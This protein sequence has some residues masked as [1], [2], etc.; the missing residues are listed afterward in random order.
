MRNMVED[1]LSNKTGPDALFTSMSA[2]KKPRSTIRVVRR[3]RYLHESAGNLPVLLEHSPD[4]VVLIDPHSIEVSWAIL[5]CNDVTC[6]INGYTRKELIGRSIDILNIHPADPEERAQ[7]MHR[8]RTEGT[9]HIE[10]WHKHKNG[11]LLPIEVSTSLVNLGGRELVLGIDRDIS[12]RKCSE[13]TLER[14]RRQLQLILVSAG[15]GILG[16]DMAGN[17]TF[18]NPAAARMVGWESEQL[19]G[20]HMH[21][22]LHHSHAGGGHYNIEECPIYAVLKDGIARHVTDEMFWRND[23]SSFP[24]EYFSTPIL[25]EQGDLEGTV[26]TF[27]DISE[28][29]R[30]DEALRQSEERFAKAFHAG[31]VPIVITRATDSLIVDVNESFLQISGF[32]RNEAV[33]RT[34]LELGIWAN[35]AEREQLRQ[36]VSEHGSVREMEVV[37]RTKSGS[38]RIGLCYVEPIYLS[39]ELCLLNIVMDITERKQAE[40]Q[41]AAYANAQTVLLQQLMTIQEA[42]RRR[43]SMDIHDGPLQSLGVSLMALDRAKLRYE[44]GEHDFAQHELAYLRTNLKGTVDEIRAILAD[45]SQEVLSTYGLIVALQSHIDRFSDVT[46]ID[47]SLRHS[48]ERRLP[49]DT[50]LLMYRLTQEALANIRKHAQAHNVTILVEIADDV[51]HM[52]IKDDG[53][54]FDVASM[55]QLYEDGKSMGLKSMYQRIRAAGG[56]LQITSLPGQGTSLEFRCPLPQFDTD[57]LQ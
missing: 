55:Y 17:A 9:L 27:M 54:G 22:T 38:S 10:A 29:K 49:A 30:S 1:R 48:I 28:R 40:E 20:R 3:H 12:D 31:P 34:A 33:G 2:G 50:E 6:R 37:F 56:D 57:A 32:S 26:L 18:V 4:A 8:L 46:A 24:V 45:L 39:G 25:S 7:Y 51:L 42:E 52:T 11:T 44:R 19:I 23:G 13:E 43:L 47:V 35:N 16:L 41:L 21:D 36:S 14:L 5:D 15:E 53:V